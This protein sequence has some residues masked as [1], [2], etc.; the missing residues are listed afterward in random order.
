M[1]VGQ[2]IS[3]IDSQLRMSGGID[4]TLNFELP[5][6]LHARIL[7]SPYAH[8]RVLKVDTSRAERLAGVA[9]VLS[10][11]DLIGDRIDP[12]FGLIIQDQTPV[13][14]DKVRFVGDAVAAVAAVDEDTAAEALDLLDVEYEELPAVFD[15]E[16]ALKPDAVLLH[17][18]ARRI[19]PGRPDVAARSL[20]GTNI[21]HLFK[22]RKGDIAR[23][24]RESDEIFDNTFSSPPVNHVALEPHVAVAQVSDGQITVWTCSQN[25]YVVQR[26]LA[27][28]F[29][30]PLADVRVIVFTLGGGFGGKLNCKFEP[31]AALLSKKAGRPVK[32]IARRNEVFLLGVQHECKVKL[33]T[34]VKRDGTLIAVEAR[35]Y[36]NSG[37]YGDT[38]PNLITR[39]YAAG[40]PYR[41]PNLYMDSYGVYTNIAPTAAFRGYGIT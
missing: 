35:C 11:D 26:Q 32:I 40:G 39:G 12:Y 36:Y 7:R 2:A 37:A 38:T 19:I 21:V 27:G 9:A 24:F 33:K 23:G 25:P 16:Q 30:I 14:L 3:M 29:K 41:V 13:A 8:A 1:A 10:R 17:E 34:G 22:Q 28:I 15:P 20:A 31:V 6:M 18:G 4:Y 5:R